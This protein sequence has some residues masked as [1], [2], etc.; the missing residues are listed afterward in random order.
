MSCN[1]SSNEKDITMPVHSTTQNFSL[2]GKW[3]IASTGADTN[4]PLPEFLI[5]NEK[6]N[7]SIEGKEGQFHPLL[8]GGYYE[9][10]SLKKE[11]RINTA[12]DAMK[13][14]KVKEKNNS[15]AIYENDQLVAE[16]KKAND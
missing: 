11:L 8:D 9:Y 14:F 4:Y 3:K 5:F 13:Q 7:Y 2:S 12:N 1:L 16:Y 10:D 15:F 6:N